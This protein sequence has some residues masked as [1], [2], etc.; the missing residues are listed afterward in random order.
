MGQEYYNGI[1]YGFAGEGVGGV[2]SSE[3]FLRRKKPRADD[4]DNTIGGAPVC[5]QSSMWSRWMQVQEEE[6]EGYSLS[7]A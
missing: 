2:L 5:H 6:L 1:D 4:F 7:I 3:E